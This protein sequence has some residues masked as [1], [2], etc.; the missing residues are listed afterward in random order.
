MNDDIFRDT[1]K[2]EDEEE[3]F[4]GACLIGGGML[5][6]YFCSVVWYKHWFISLFILLS[7]I[8]LLKVGLEEFERG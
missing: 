1:S 8:F 4:S 5:L 7:G 6:G 3:G 2:D